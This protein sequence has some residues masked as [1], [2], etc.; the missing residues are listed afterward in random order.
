MK[1][2]FKI[3]KSRNLCNLLGLL[4]FF[5]FKNLIHKHF[6]FGV[7]RNC[8][9]NLKK[10]IKIDIN[11]TQG[12]FS[13]LGWCELQINLQFIF[14]SR[15]WNWDWLRN[16]IC[17]C[18]FKVM[19]IFIILYMY[20]PKLILLHKNKT[21][22]INSNYFIFKNLYFTKSSFKAICNKNRSLKNISL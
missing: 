9:K 17:M 13:L 20:T 11:L 22:K 2:C 12:R 6:Y 14:S 7:M 5:K 21:M 4:Y 19:Y 15:F 18:N 8:Y 1:R 16:L 3:K 10:L